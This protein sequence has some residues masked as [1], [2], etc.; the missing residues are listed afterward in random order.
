MA[1]A[2]GQAGHAAIERQVVQA[3]VNEERESVDGFFEQVAGDAFLFFVELERFEEVECFVERE[4]A[5][6]GK[7]QLM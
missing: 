3:D 1:L 5:E 6:L 4:E 2:A 7:G